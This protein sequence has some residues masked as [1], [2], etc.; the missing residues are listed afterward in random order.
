MPFEI[1][2]LAGLSQPVT[3]LIEVVSSAL[4]T[5][6]RPGNVV[7]D[8]DARA[9]EIKA[10]ARAEAEAEEIRRAVKLDA[11]VDRIE[12]ATGGD[13]AL[14]ARARQRLLTRELEGQLNVEAIANEAIAA[15]PAA[16]SNDP[17]N[18]DWRRKFFLH[19]ENVCEADMQ[20]LW[21]KVLAGE[22]A[23]PGSFSVRT[24][25]VLRNLSKH[26]AETFRRA[27]TCAMQDGWIALPGHDMNTALVPHG[28]TYTDILTLRDAGLL[29]DGD[30]LHKNF[31]AQGLVPEPSKLQLVLFNNQTLIQVSG[32]PLQHLRISSLIFTTA[33]RE[34]QRLIEP[35]PNEHYFKALGA[36][37]RTQSLTVKRGIPV[38]QDGGQTILSFEA[39]L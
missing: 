14:A 30:N 10:I 32:P 21:G 13:Q 26:E 12:S 5:R 31:S 34:L 27:C 29:A 22:I 16:V 19:A 23:T 36:Y 24:L 6:F 20:F 4:G 18:E 35:L 28:I 8:A 15:L 17:V 1:K 3:K 37:L 33:G 11:L 2:D 25:D 39:D 9:Y 7:R 38:V